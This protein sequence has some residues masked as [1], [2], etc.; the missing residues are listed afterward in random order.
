MINQTLL[1][2]YFSTEW[3]GRNGQYKYGGDALISKINK[4]E[5]VLD[6]GCGENYYKGKIPFLI[7]IDPANDNADV[8]TTI[9]DYNPTWLK[10]DVA[11]CL[12]SVNFGTKEDIF[13]QIDKIVSLLKPKGRIYWRCN[14]GHKDHGTEGCQQLDIFPWTKELLIEYAF[15]YG[16]TPATI[17]DDSGNRIYAEWVRG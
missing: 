4:D 12:G 3:R 9:E 8:K 15:K 17:I 14:P 10:F 2:Q 5:V 16:F 11:F 13:T 1:N 6:V 7:G